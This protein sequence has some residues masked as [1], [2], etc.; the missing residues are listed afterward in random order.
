MLVTARCIGGIAFTSLMIA[1]MYIGEISPAD[2]R[3]KRVSINQL[4]IVVGLSAAY[5][6][7]YFILNLSTSGAQWVSNLG[8]DVNTWRW[9]L[10]LEII[11][12]LVF[13]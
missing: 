10:G 1:P 7:N 11:P 2:Q 3:G 4:N 8:I 5:F 13:F 9:M 12:A 6:A